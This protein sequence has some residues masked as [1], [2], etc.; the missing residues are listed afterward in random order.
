MSTVKIWAGA[1]SLFT[2][3]SIA[4]LLALHTRQPSNQ[5]KQTRLFCCFWLALAPVAQQAINRFHKAF[6]QQPSKQSLK[7]LKGNSFASLG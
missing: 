5:H 3:Q 7:Y 4:R 1:G 2:R 6:K